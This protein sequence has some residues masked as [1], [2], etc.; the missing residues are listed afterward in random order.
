MATE[1]QRK[2]NLIIKTLSKQSYIYSATHEE[3]DNL[4]DLIHVNFKDIEG[5]FSFQVPIFSP[6][7]VLTQIPDFHYMTK[8]FAKINEELGV[9]IDVI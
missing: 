6:F 5:V 9:T 2:I 7:N 1:Y 4:Y 3:V 8:N